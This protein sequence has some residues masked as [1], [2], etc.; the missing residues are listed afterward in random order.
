M[1]IREP[2]FGRATPWQ[3]LPVAPDAFDH[4]RTAV[5]RLAGDTPPV[6]QALLACDE[7]IANVASYSGAK[8]FAFRCL[9]QDGALLVGFRDDG[10]PFDPT[11]EQ[12]G[13]PQD[14]ES[15]DLGGMGLGLIR[16]TAAEMRYAREGDENHLALR[17]SLE[18]PRHPGCVSECASHVVEP[19]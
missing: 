19:P 2:L 7:W 15:F 13:D 3:A 18:P 9:L 17:F 16:Q 6:R 11:Q 1:D 5:I 12:D 10:I 14:F 4:V 8:R